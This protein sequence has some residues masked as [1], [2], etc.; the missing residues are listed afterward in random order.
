MQ[1]VPPAR[2][3]DQGERLQ[4]FLARAGIAS[5]RQC[6][7]LIEAGRVQVNGEIVRVQGTRVHPGRDRV[8]LDGEEVRAERQVTVL[9]NKPSGYISSRSDPEGRPVV[10][11]LVAEAGFP[12]LFPVGRLD[13][14]TEGLLL[15]TNDGALA[16]ALTHPRYAVRKT[17][18]AKVKGHPTA[19][20]LARLTRGV[21][22]EGEK[23]TAVSVDRLHPTRQ[24]AWI[25]ITLDEGRYR[26]VRRM[27]EAI[28]HP[29]QRL[30]RVA[31][32]PLRL[33]SLPRG[34]WRP[35]SSA[36]L[37]SLYA[38]IPS[39]DPSGTRA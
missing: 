26:Q 34:Q 38:L 25:A 24:N 7:T 1:A 18:H 33:G 16:N 22:S 3:A 28:G 21:V 8:Q 37:R 5:R 32:G 15:L 10:T 6:E 14:D 23:L 20:S 13:W 17:Y 19:E 2:I 29:V 4:K 9:L 31:L 35:L 11:S 39:A 12:H 36:E 27:C 30:T